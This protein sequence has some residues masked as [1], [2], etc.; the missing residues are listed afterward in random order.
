M[1][2]YAVNGAPMGWVNHHKV[3]A[4]K[5]RGLDRPIRLTFKRD[6]EGAE[7]GVGTAPPIAEEKDEAAAEGEVVEE[8]ETEAVKEEAEGAGG[9]AAPGEVEEKAN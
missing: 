3:L 7:G 5:I 6:V 8:T 9:T 2:V 4:E 1:I